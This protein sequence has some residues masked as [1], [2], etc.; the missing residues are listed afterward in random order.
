MIGRL[1]STVIK[2]TTLPI[3][4]ANSAMDMMCGGSGSKRSRTQDDT[5]LAMLE[6]L[7]DQAAQTAEKIDEN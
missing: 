3:D 6:K 7:R 4:V 5:P 1:L 2:V